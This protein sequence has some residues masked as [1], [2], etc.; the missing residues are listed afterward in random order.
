M[1]IGNSWHHCFS[2]P[3]SM[4]GAIC[5]LVTR[6]QLFREKAWLAFGHDATRLSSAANNREE[7]VWCV[8]VACSKSLI[9]DEIRQLIREDIVWRVCVACSKS[10]ITD[11]IRQLIRK[12]QFDNWAWEEYEMLLLLRQ[13]FIDLNLV[14]DL[15]IEVR[16]RASFGHAC[17][18]SVWCNLKFW[19]KGHFK[20]CVE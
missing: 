13:M 9:A 8:C 12:T 6:V 1:Q 5:N 3:W 14:K 10:L 17:Y 4:H 16:R 7:I 2:E 20:L 18:L 11:E 15:K 19:R